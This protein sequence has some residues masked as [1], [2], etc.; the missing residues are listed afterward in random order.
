MKR[1][2]QI[3]VLVA[4]AIAF[5]ALMAWRESRDGSQ[6]AGIQPES[7]TETNAS[8][9]VLLFADPREAEA[10]CGCGLIFHA[11]REAAASGLATREVDPERELELV[12]QHRV[13]VEPTVIF[14][15]EEGHETSR[16][17]GEAGETI[18]AIEAELARLNG[19]R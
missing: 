15:D 10:T 9:R 11:V 8:P 13:T 6:P 3:T 16:W 12:A 5:V 7:G 1:S 14:L 19:E 4:V 18:A 2:W 17:E